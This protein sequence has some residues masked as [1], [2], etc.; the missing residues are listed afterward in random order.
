MAQASGSQQSKFHRRLKISAKLY[1]LS[2]LYPGGLPCSKDFLKELGGIY[3]LSFV[4][5]TYEGT[6]SHHC[7]FQDDPQYTTSSLA[8]IKNFQ[9]IEHLIHLGTVNDMVRF[10]EV[11]ENVRIGACSKSNKSREWYGQAIVDME[12]VN[13][14]RKKKGKTGIV[15]LPQ[16]HHYMMNLAS[17]RV[18]GC[19][20]Q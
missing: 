18:E 12:K 5:V 4:A 14:E 3:Q 2:S 7:K 1:V 8:E 16:W 11:L 20:V 13:K 19:I 10:V 17:K 9:G 15:E 6:Q